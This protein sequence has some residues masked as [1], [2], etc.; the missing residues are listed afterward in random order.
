MNRVVSILMKRDGMTK[1]EAVNYLNDV[2][3]EL[4]SCSY[5]PEECEDIIYDEL[6]LEL[7]YLDDILF[8]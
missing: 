1:V 5:N 7:D 2:R 3:R 8:G 4:E 6:G